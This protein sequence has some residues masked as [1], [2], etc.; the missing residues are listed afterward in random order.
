MFTFPA[1]D[2]TTTQME[3]KSIPPTLMPSLRTNH[4]P[5]FHH[6]GGTWP[7]PTSYKWR[8]KYVIFGVIYPSCSILPIRSH[9]YGVLSRPT[10]WRYHVSITY[11]TLDGYLG[12]FPFGGALTNKAFWTISYMSFGKYKHSL[13]LSLYL[14]E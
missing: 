11:S 10:I 7:G 3:W 14:V 5:D 13:Q 4:C 12:C 2:I 6:H 9:F 1:S 8:I